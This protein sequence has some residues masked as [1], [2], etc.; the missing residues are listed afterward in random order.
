MNKTLLKLLAVMALIGFSTPAF[1]Q[2]ANDDGTATANIVTAMTL[3][4]ERDLA[5]GTVVAPS[6]DSCTV[7]LTAAETAVVG[8]DCSSSGTQT[9]AQFD[10]TGDASAEYSITLPV[11]TI[12]MTGAGDPIVVGTFT[13]SA[14]ATPTLSGAGAATFYVGATA[15][16]NDGQTGGAYTGTFNVAVDY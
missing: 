14:G 9:S 10:V 16:V 5:F 8:G 2:G 1:A 13:H 3:S 12:N 6:G 4:A 15:T 7:S 11:G